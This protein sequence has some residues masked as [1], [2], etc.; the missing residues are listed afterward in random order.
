MRLRKRHFYTFFQRHPDY[1]PIFIPCECGLNAEI[2]EMFFQAHSMVFSQFSRQTK[3]VAVFEIINSNFELL[4][5]ISQERKIPTSRYYD[6]LEFL[7]FKKNMKNKFLI[8]FGLKN[9]LF[10][11]QTTFFF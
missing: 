10:L 2:F 3:V 11:K 9:R 6:K 8:F 5:M 7:I 1:Y 4:R